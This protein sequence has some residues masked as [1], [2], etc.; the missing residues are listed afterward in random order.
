M[1]NQKK[2][3]VSIQKSFSI[4]NHAIISKFQWMKT[5]SSNTRTKTMMKGMA[6]M[7]SMRMRRDLL[8]MV[9][10]LQG[11]KECRIITFNNSTITTDKLLAILELISSEVFR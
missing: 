2:E 4:D 11:I 10:T 9:T 1:K 6:W 8:M 7:K 5:R 3:Y